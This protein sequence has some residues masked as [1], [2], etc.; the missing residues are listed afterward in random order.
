MIERAGRARP[1]FP[2]DTFSYVQRSSVAGAV[3][4]PL[5]CAPEPGQ[6]HFG[7][8]PAK[9]A[10][11][12]PIAHERGAQGPAKHGY[13]VAPAEGGLAHGHL[14][15]RAFRPGSV[16]CRHAGSPGAQPRAGAPRRRDRRAVGPPRRR[17]RSPA[18]PHPRVRCP[19]RLEQWL[20][21]LRRL[22]D[23]ARR[24][25]PGRR[26]RARAGGA[27]PGR[28]APAG[29]RARPRRA[30][31]LEGPRADARGD[32]RNRRAA[33]RRGPGRHDRARG[34]DRPRLAPG[35]PAGRGARG[36]PAAR[37]PGP[38]RVSGQR[39]HGADQG[40]AD[41]RGGRPARAGAGRRPGGALPAGRRQDATRTF[42]LER[43]R[44]SSSR[45]TPSPCWRRPPSTRASTPATPA[46]ATRS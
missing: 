46:S 4:M 1:Q 25:R 45:R 32:S 39:R 8:V 9:N 29:R 7:V 34:A 19:R 27:R 44:W 11:R 26:P 33:A 16:H 40:P 10:D 6:G 18:R 42:Q 3:G 31:V 5:H 37:E 38:A 14:H 41:R 2:L 36:S 22:A 43:R 28:A 30:V 17:H 24:P 12:R 35:G 23:L 21:L 20:P 15:A 13:R